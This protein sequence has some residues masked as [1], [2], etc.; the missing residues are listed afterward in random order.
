MKTT[1]RI[2]L[3]IVLA[4]LLLAPMTM[5]LAAAGRD[6]SRC[7]HACNSIKG[8]CNTRCPDDCGV[9]FPNDKAAR[10]AC[11]SQCRATCIE[12]GKECRVV[13]KSI[14]NPSSDAEP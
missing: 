3:S 1:Q 9:L 14:K 10:D 6:Y 8:N 11:I 7:I 4:G 5:T 12:E 13:C 2:A